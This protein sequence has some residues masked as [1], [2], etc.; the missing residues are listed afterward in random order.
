MKA[1]VGG[2][3]GETT[4]QIIRGPVVVID[5]STKKKKRKGIENTV[6]PFNAHE[7]PILLS[8]FSFAAALVHHMTVLPRFSPAA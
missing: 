8:G 3:E 6:V 2:A 5:K 1:L 4:S 7:G